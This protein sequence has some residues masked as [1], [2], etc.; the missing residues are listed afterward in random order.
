MNPEG[1][2]GEV[3]EDEETGE[4]ATAIGAHQEMGEGSSGEAPADSEGQ[5]D[6]REDRE[7]GESGETEE[8]EAFDP[9]WQPRGR[10]LVTVDGVLNWK[11]PIKANCLK[12][13][14][15]ARFSNEIDLASAKAEWPDIA[16]ELRP[17]QSGSGSAD[18][19]D[20]LERLARINVMLGVEDNFITEDST[21]YDVTIQKF[22]YRPGALMEIA[23]KEVRERLLKKCWR[24]LYVTMAGESFCEGRNASMDDY[25][26]ITFADAGDGV[27]RPRPWFSAHCAAEEVLNT[28]AETGLRLASSTACR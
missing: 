19:G 12:E 13:M 16:D 3:P 17:S 1:P 24:G 7:E 25:L 5:E 21:V 9:D 11:L 27:H 6:N 22:W 8:P 4:A 15:W 23:N 28:L 14:P 18:D 10:E 26:A 2:E 20:D